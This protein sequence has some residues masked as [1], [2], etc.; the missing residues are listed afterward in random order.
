VIWIEKHHKDDDTGIHTIQL[1]VVKQK[2]SDDGKRIWLQSQPVAVPFGGISARE[3]I[4]GEA[5]EIPF[6]GSRA[7]VPTRKHRGAT[8]PAS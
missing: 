4:E 7:T 5:K 8:G 2:D 1:W 6:S 3:V